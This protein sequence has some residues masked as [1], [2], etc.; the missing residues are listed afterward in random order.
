[1][2]PCIVYLFHPDHAYP[3]RQG[4]SIGEFA[5]DLYKYTN[6]AAWH[7]SWR[8]KGAGRGVFPQKPLL[9]RFD[10]VTLEQTEGNIRPDIVGIA[11][12]RKL[13]IEVAVTHFIDDEKLK[14]LRARGT[15]T[16]E[17]V[18]PYEENYESNW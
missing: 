8:E 18:V 11:R 5:H 14:R 16:I 2:P 10:S 15:P 1:I 9:I 3:V 12:G 13:Y 17:L 7:D 4:L 6:N